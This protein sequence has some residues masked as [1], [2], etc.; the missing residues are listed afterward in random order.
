VKLAI[1]RAGVSDIEV[2]ARFNEA[3]AWETEH[4]RLDRDRL[5]AGV[6]GL[7]GESDRGFYLLAEADGLVAGQ[8]MITYEWSDWRNGVFWWIQSVYVDVGYRKLGIFKELYRRVE[9]LAQEAGNVCGIRLYVER[10]N[11]RA[12]GVYERLGM[13][14]TAYEMLEMDYVINR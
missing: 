6:A 3:M 12:Q 4:L 2:V 1:R 7:L 10:E 9:T 13:K 11:V 14:K 5:R 8:L